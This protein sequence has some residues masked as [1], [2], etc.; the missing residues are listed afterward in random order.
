MSAVSYPKPL[1]FLHGPF[2]PTFYVL[3]AVPLRP[4]IG[5]TDGTLAVGY[6]FQLRTARLRVLARWFPGGIAVGA[7]AR[8]IGP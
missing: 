8:V 4:P 5:Q 1:L 6:L 3:F 7:L 2:A